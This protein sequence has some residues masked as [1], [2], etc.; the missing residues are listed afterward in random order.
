MTGGAAA[1]TVGR[2]PICAAGRFRRRAAAIA[3]RSTTTGW[4]GSG[5]ERAAVLARALVGRRACRF[6]RAVVRRR[7]GRR[8][9]PDRRVRR[10]LDGM[11]FERAWVGSAQSPVLHDR[12]GGEAV[13]GWGDGRCRLGRV[14]GAGRGSVL[15]DTV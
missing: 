13:A 2:N 12:C 9:T 3:G 7:R 8:N 10:R 4:S 11:V 6:L 14:P 5:W 1:D 15:R